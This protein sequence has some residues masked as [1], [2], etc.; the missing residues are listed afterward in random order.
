MSDNKHTIAES[1]CFYQG[2]KEQIFSRKF[3]D[4]S[5]SFQITQIYS[6]EM[7][8]D[9]NLN[10]YK[11]TFLSKINHLIQRRMYEGGDF[12][13]INSEELQVKKVRLLNDNFSSS[14][15]FKLYPAQGICLK[16]GCRQ[17]FDLYENRLCGHKNN[18]PWE[19]ITFVAFCD[20]CGWTLPLHYM[21]NLTKKCECGGSLSKLNWKKKDDIGSYKVK[22]TKCHT[23]KP[24]IFVSCKHIEGTKKRS[25]NPPYR[26]RGAPARAN[27]LL[28]PYVITIPDVTSSKQDDLFGET[29]SNSLFSISFEHFFLDDEAKIN[30]PRFK[31]ALTEQKNFVK[32]KGIIQLL[33]E[34]QLENSFFI[35]DDSFKFIIQESIIKAY[36]LSTKSSLDISTIRENYGINI[37]GDILKSLECVQ[38]TEEDLQGYFLSNDHSIP[39]RKN[40]TNLEYGLIQVSHFSDLTMVQGLLGIIEG[41]TR[42]P[43]LLYHPLETNSRSNMDKKPIVYYRTFKTEG[44]LFQLNPQQILKWLKLNGKISSL[45]SHDYASFLLDLTSEDTHCLDAVK[46]LIH[47][48]SHLLIQQSAINT[49]LDIQSLSEMIW[50]KTGCFL[51]YSTNSINIGGLEYVYDYHLQNWFNSMKESSEDCPQDPGC[52]IDE[53]GACNCCSYLPEFVC[54]NFNNNLDRSALIGGGGTD[55]FEIGY[56]DEGYFNDI[57]KPLC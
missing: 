23:E 56:F 51:I 46:T 13:L 48:Y 29:I 30:L 49:G 1:S 24:L 20:E 45:P 5:L 18:D 28:H 11:K 52:M 8:I 42:R 26:F 35:E 39:S 36:K 14:G 44:L 2:N 9:V 57:D 4:K 21:S 12:F 33:E 53:G 50:P 3:G 43:T 38:Y 32:S 47:T 25:T 31:A 34:Y 22:C 10:K 16:D 55:R 15:K 54:C 41:S 27:S 6:D 37:I 17:Y 19:Q 7:N 40:Q